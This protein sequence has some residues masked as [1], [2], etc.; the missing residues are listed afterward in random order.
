MKKEGLTV[1]DLITIG[2][3]T[4]IYFVAFFVVGMIGFIPVTMPFLPFFIGIVGGIPILLLVTKTQKFGALSISGIIVCLL[5]FFT[6]HPWTILVIGIPFTIL[7]DCIMYFGKYRNWGCIVVGYICY[8]LWYL[9]AFAP[10]YF[11]RESYFKS[12]AAGYG[13][14]YVRT[15]DNVLSIK[16]LPIVIVLS[17]LGSVIGVYIAKAALNKHFK[18]AGII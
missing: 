5:M 10:F 11:M 7:G 9:G 13:D 2:L 1:K 6:G 17:I 12:I 3:F 15:L 16:M 14:D 4:A 18:R 8:S